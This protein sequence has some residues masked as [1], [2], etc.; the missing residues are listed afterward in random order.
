MPL[1]FPG[2]TPRVLNYSTDSSV[3]YYSIH[4]IQRNSL[5]ETRLLIRS[6]SYNWFNA[7]PEDENLDGRSWTTKTTSKRGVTWANQADPA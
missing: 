2:P 4:L 7:D 1:A 3:I 6:L 5:Y